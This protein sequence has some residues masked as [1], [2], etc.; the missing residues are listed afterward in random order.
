MI[1]GAL[2]N[3]GV[4]PSA[5]PKYLGF[6]THLSWFIRLN[7]NDLEITEEQFKGFC[8]AYSAK[9]TSSDPKE[10]LE[11]LCRA[12]ILDNPNDSI[13]FTY[14]YSYYYFLGRYANSFI[15]TEEVKSYLA[16]CM[17]NLYVR[18]C[19]NTLLFLAHHSDNSFVL[20][21]V[22]A[23]LASH[24]PDAAPATFEKKDVAKLTSLMANAPTL[25]YQQ[26]APVTHRDDINRFRDANHSD[27]DGLHSEPKPAGEPRDL[28]E[29][30]T[31]LSKTMEIAGVLLTNHFS[32]LTR[33][34][35]NSAIALIFESG[36]KL[37]SDFFHFIERDPE[38]IVKEISARSQSK[39]KELTTAQAET[40]ARHAIAWLIKIISVSWI[41]KAG[42][43]VTSADLHD[44]VAE[45]I[46]AA[47]SLGLRLI[48]ISQLLDGPGRLP[49]ASIK[50]IIKTELDN[51][52]V[53]SVLQ[54]LVLKRLYMYDTDHDDKD[55]AISTFQ[56]GAASN[57]IELT[58]HA[59]IVP[60]T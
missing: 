41:E 39:R 56:L 48:E 5:L 20:D 60:A 6:A 58:R 30:I 10:M 36:L 37:I 1:V 45:V 16:Y 13:C 57:R 2:E 7:G 27:S 19:A 29:E 35:K 33:E 53:M 18:E 40:E 11:I 25:L 52:C 44:N 38:R 23:A 49:Q 59:L 34:R 28:V 54:L 50:A 12:R 46:S 51:P 55:W 17:Q 9:W 26:K 42:T 21:G 3:A 31:S 47:P 8:H 32:S 4:K 43:H 15:D 14:Q 22:V 24:F